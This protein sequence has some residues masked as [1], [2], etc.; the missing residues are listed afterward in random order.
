VSEIVKYKTV[1]ITVYPWKHPSGRSY[2]RYKSNGK[3][4]TRS[5][6]EV[7]KKE[8]LEYARSIFR[9]GPDMQALT[10]EQKRACQRMIEADPTCGLVDEFLVWHAKRAPKKNS[11][12]AVEEFLREKERNQGS[13]PHNVTTL[14]R[15]LSLIPD[16]TL[17]DIG[18]GDLPAL[19]GAPRTRKNIRAAWVTFF[20]WSVERGFL[21]HGEKTA[22]E[23]VGKPIVTRG[24]PSTWT[25]D[26]LRILLAACRVQYRPWLALCALGG[27][28]TEEVI[29]QQASTKPPLTWEDIHFDRDLIIVRP[30]TS[31]TGQRRVIPL[32]PALKSWLLPLAGQGVIG[33]HLYPSKPSTHGTLSETARLGALVGGWRRNALRHSFISFRAAQCGSLGQTALEAGNSESEARRSYN[34]AKSKKEADAWFGVFSECS[35]LMP[36]PSG[37]TEHQEVTN[38]SK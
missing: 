36:P 8:A 23:K 13:S 16:M 26:E 15:H 9:G 12:E 17:G 32:C 5:S 22:A 28:R 14:K 20:K 1:T 37:T 27:L 31:K 18:P 29:P 21:P 35:P 33:P 24:I 4:V 11:R 3:H 38:Q 34:D 7:A 10:H 25:P 6:L 19:K 2:W 30:E